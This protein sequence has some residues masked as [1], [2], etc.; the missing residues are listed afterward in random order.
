M[1]ITADRVDLSSLGAGI[2]YFETVCFDYTVDVSTGDG[3][4]YIH[5]PKEYAGMKL[6]EV[7][8]LVITA[9]T[10]GTTDIQ[11]HN[12]TGAV[13]MLTTVITIDSGETGSD[14][15]ATPPVINTSNNT[16]AENDVLRVDIDA[17]SSTA[18]KGL[19]V[20]MGFKLP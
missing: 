18:P 6:V 7:H 10:T 1:K 20:T 19:I 3:G 11:L 17:V 13:D 14:T 8:A 5:V 2:R 15:A 16:V 4:S 9:G 12:V